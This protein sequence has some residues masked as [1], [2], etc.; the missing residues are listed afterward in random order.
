MKK[1]CT[2]CWLFDSGRIENAF[3]G[4]EVFSRLFEQK[5]LFENKGEMVFFTGDIIDE[6]IASDLVIG[7]C[8]GAIYIFSDHVNTFALGI[9]VANAQLT[10]Y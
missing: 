8:Y 10:L 7:S 4:K 5:C 6:N 1:I 3:Y 2:I 9:I